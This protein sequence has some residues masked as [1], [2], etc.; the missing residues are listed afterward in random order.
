MYRVKKTILVSASHSLLLHKGAVREPM[1][2]HNWKI[3]VYCKSEELDEDGF[4]ADFTAIETFLKKSLDHR[5]LGEVL[6]CN[7]STE[8]LAKWICDRVD[9]CYKV[10]VEECEG[11][12]A[13]YEKP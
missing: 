5:D 7:P 13:C 8:N 2:G 11:N 4:V 1:H 10:E 9:K 6:P 12:E 3:T